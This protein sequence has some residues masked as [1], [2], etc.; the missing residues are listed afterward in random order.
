MTKV[1][2]SPRR[3]A[4]GDVPVVGKGA[5]GT[6]DGSLALVRGHAPLSFSLR[7]D[8]SEKSWVAGN[9]WLFDVVIIVA[10]AIASSSNA[11]SK[12]ITARIIVRGVVNDGVCM[13]IDLNCLAITLEIVLAILHQCA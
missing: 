8:L 13:I 7:F 1:G 2:V 10:S 4:I 6:I 11:V 5:L 3:C 12:S 9:T